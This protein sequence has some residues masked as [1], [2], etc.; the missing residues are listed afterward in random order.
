MYLFQTKPLL[1]H[2]AH[3]R[4][5]DARRHLEVNAE[6]TRKLV[7]RFPVLYQ[8]YDSPMTQTCMY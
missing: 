4:G 3:R 8:D 7:K 5:G 6:L 1:I 2:I